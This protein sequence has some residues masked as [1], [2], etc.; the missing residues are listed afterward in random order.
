LPGGHLPLTGLEVPAA[1]GVPEGAQ[2]PPQPLVV[3][4]VR[5]GAAVVVWTVA[6]CWVVVWEADDRVVV[7]LVLVDEVG[8][9]LVDVVVGD[10][11][12]VAVAVLVPVVWAAAVAVGPVELLD[13]VCWL[14]Q[15]VSA[16]SS[17]AVAKR[18]VRIRESTNAKG[19][20]LGGRLLQTLARFAHK[21][22]GFGEDGGHDGPQLL[23]LLIGRALDV[24]P[25]DRGH[26]QIDGQLDRV[27]GPGQ[28]LGTLHL[29]CKLAELALQ[30]VRVAEESSEA[31]AFHVLD[32]SSPRSATQ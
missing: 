17:A 28:L 10:C 1:E 13:V 31:A 25:V 9:E 8:V 5:V 2:S 19:G 23:G 27:V 22:H 12:L 3:V 6:V 21:G 7:V 18:H 4:L 30:I 29:L 20:V 11:E 26:R 16:V 14:P 15:P 32:G 24:D